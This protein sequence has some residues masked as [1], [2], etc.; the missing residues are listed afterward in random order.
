MALRAARGNRE[1]EHVES[2]ESEPEDRASRKPGAK[3]ARPAFRAPDRAGWA[4]SPAPSGTRKTRGGGVGPGGLGIPPETEAQD[5]AAGS[6][7]RKGRAG[8]GAQAK[9]GQPR[10]RP[11]AGSKSTRGKKAGRGKRLPP[12]C[13]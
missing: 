5:E 12:K 6:K 11:P 3:R 7:S 10:A 1:S 2:E 8:A 9:G 13:G 4:G